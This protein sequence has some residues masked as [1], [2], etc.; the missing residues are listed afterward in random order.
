M[1][2]K[3]ILINFPAYYY[4]LSKQNI[5]KRLRSSKVHS[6][7]EK[8]RNEKFINLEYRTDI[9]ITKLNFSC[10]LSDAKL[11]IKNKKILVDFYANQSC[12]SLTIDHKLIT[13]N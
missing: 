13:L 11:L 1:L 7:H 10:S 5:K 6:L 8:L 9:L 4:K 12:N 2:K 3:N